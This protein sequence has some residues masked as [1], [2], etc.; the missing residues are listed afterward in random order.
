[1]QIVLSDTQLQWQKART[2]GANARE[3][4]QEAG[5]IIAAIGPHHLPYSSGLLKGLY[6]TIAQ[7]KP[8]LRTIVLMAP[9]HYQAAA[10]SA[11]TAAITYETSLGKTYT[12]DSLFSEL[13]QSGLVLHDQQVFADEHAVY[14]HI[15]YIQTYLPDVR[16]VPLLIR[17][18][19]QGQEAQELG[20]WLAGRLPPDTLLILSTDLSHY[21]PAELARLEDQDTVEIL[22]TI[23][24][25]RVG[26]AITDAGP[27]LVVLFTFLNQRNSSE[28][29]VLGTGN[30]ADF[31]ADRE[32]TTGYATLVYWVSR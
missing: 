28:G 20:V 21:Q 15:P 25:S 17:P 11:V 7:N 31:G 14:T 22:Q 30:Q 2:Y 16:I 18:D 19:M 8:D 29:I 13:V 27:A 12:D 4:P 24:S 32:S 23:D 26:E 9:D 6:E 10:E 3:L 5:Q 1:M